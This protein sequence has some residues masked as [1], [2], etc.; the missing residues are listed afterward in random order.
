[1]GFSAANAQALSA[2]PYIFAVLCL[3][4]CG[5]FSDKYRAR[6]WAVVLPSLLGFV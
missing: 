2:P 4:P 6:T 5:Y 1:M 3:L